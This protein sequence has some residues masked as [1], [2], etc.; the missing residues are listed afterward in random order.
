MAERLFFC[1][2]ATRVC[3]GSAEK[4]ATLDSTLAADILEALMC[5]KSHFLTVPSDLP[6]LASTPACVWADRSFTSSLYSNEPN[7]T[8]AS[9]VFV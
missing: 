8:S 1:P 2:W 6:V 4:L 3:R 5:R 9:A 7:N